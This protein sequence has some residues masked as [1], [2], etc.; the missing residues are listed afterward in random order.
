MDEQTERKIQEQ[1]ARQDWR[2]VGVG[3]WPEVEQ[4]NRLRRLVDAHVYPPES[5]LDEPPGGFDSHEALCRTQLPD[6]LAELDRGSS[7]AIPHS[8]HLVVVKLASVAAETT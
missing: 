2:E 4:A 8:P 5:I 6:I 7:D 3:N 1:A